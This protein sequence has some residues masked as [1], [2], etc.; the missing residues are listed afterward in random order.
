M[1]EETLHQIFEF[2]IS[3]YIRMSTEFANKYHELVQ[4]YESQLAELLEKHYKICE[5]LAWKWW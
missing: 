1:R 4:K 2:S 5:Y 3:K